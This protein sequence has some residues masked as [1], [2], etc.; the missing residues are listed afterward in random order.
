LTIEPTRLAPNRGAPALRVGPT[1]IAWLGRASLEWRSRIG[2]TRRSVPLERPAGVTLLADGTALALGMPPALR[3]DGAVIALAPDGAVRT[4]RLA[5]HLGPDVGAWLFPDPTSLEHAWLL[6]AEPEPHLVRV[7]LPPGDEPARAVAS[8]RL[9]ARA[10]TG[11]AQLGER[12]FVVAAEGLA[13]VRG[14]WLRR[15]DTEVSRWSDAEGY[16]PLDASDGVVYAMRR[17]DVVRIAPGGDATVVATA[18]TDAVLHR[19]AAV[20]WGVLALEGRGHPG[21]ASW[22]LVAWE[23]TAAGHRVRWRVELPVR[24]RDATALDVAGDTRRV[25]VVAGDDLVVLGADD[26][27]ETSPTEAGTRPAAPPPTLEPG[28]SNATL[29]WVEPAATFDARR[30]TDVALDA[31]DAIG[32]VIAPLAIEVSLACVDARGDDI[33]RPS[34]PGVLAVTPGLPAE[35]DLEPTFVGSARREVTSL[36][37]VSLATLATTGRCD[38]GTRTW[39]ALVLVAGRVAL[40]IVRALD[41]A[42]TLAD[43]LDGEE[44]ARHG[45]RR[46]WIGPTRHGDVPLAAHLERDAGRLTLRLSLEP[47]WAETDGPAVLAG[48]VATLVRRGWAP[49]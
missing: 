20:P 16:G 18:S 29:S 41:G 8:L 33:A 44:I 34:P 38:G 10:P 47:R 28:A 13:E 46:H 3:G 35:L 15:E 43:A 1:A 12:T 31:F 27:A 14:P 23:R 26:G 49:R 19:I 25:A 11:A 9:G 42:P 45:G 2:D 17:G 6:S 48:L 4:Y 7:H 24:W 21:A 32:E 36:D 30:L 40:P 39:R 22:S 37:R 5:T